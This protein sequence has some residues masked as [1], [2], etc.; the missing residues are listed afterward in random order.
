MCRRNSILFT[1]IAAL[2]WLMAVAAGSPAAADE[3]G[4]YL[5]DR[6]LTRLHAVYLEEKLAEASGEERE[7][8][9]L[10]LASI[11]AILLATTDDPKRRD[12]LEV[13]SRALLEKSP[14]TS[15]DE[16]RLALLRGSYRSAE[17][18]A[19]KYRLRLT[20]EAELDEAKELLRAVIPDLAVLRGQLADQLDLLD[21]RLSRSSG[22]QAADISEE[23]ERVRKL[24]RQCTYLNAWGLYYASFLNERDDN[25]RAAQP[26]F[27]Q[28]MG[29]ESDYPRPDEISRDL[30][31]EESF[32]RS[33]L[34]MAMCQGISASSATAMQWL[35][36]LEH[37]NTIGSL[38]SELPAWRMAIHLGNG[39]FTDAGAVLRAVLEA[40]D[41]NNDISVPSSWLRLAAVYALDAGSGVR[42]AGDLLRFAVAE[43]AT[44]GEL[45]QI[46][47][48]AS[49]YGVQRLGGSGFVLSYVSGVLDYDRAR[50]AHG[51]EEPTTDAALVG[52]YDR[53]IDNFNEAL[54]QPD[55]SQYPSAAA[56]CRQLIAW[57]RY[58]QGRFLDARQAF[59]EAAAHLPPEEAPEALWMAIVSLE[60]A[61][62][63]GMS[64]DV[65]SD[66]AGLIDQFL[67]LYPSH[68]HAPTL[69]Y[70]KALQ[71]VDPSLETVRDLLAIPFDSEVH[72]PAQ[73]R[74]A[75]MLYSLFRSSEGDERVEYGTE[76]L[77]VAVGLLATDDGQFGEGHELE[78]AR[79]LARCRRVLEVS[80]TDGIDR[81]VAAANALRTFDELAASGT[82]DVSEHRDEIDYRRI[83]ERLGWD[84]MEAASGIADAMWGRAPE[85]VW[86]RLAQRAVFRHGRARWKDPETAMLDNRQ[87]LGLVIR[88]GRRVLEEFESDP[89]SLKD[90]RVLMYFAT[91]A[92]AAMTRWE[93]SRGDSDGRLA[94]ELY[95]K[96]V[97]ERPRNGEFLRSIAILTERYGPT[98]Q[99]LEY[100]RRLVA[101]R[102]IGSDQWYEAKFHLI[103]VLFQTDVDRA[104]E[105]MDQHKQLNDEYGPPPWGA[106]LRAL[107]L[108][109]DQKLAAEKSPTQSGG[110]G[111]P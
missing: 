2:A 55:A 18:I 28:L 90:T 64:G 65:R 23:T 88:F 49:R 96:L 104:R 62:E 78:V 42:S 108:R 50:E 85:S 20:D 13:R 43:L 6:G 93:R 32:A 102:T 79:Y 70:R 47:D 25:A 67:D 80:L 7:A 99:A 106:R 92:E 75:Q 35:S 15:A 3:L 54:T 29:A 52:N 40:E 68:E 94:L 36:L 19:E 1:S 97:D 51:G 8:I 60:R 87:A 63:V 98:E 30:R 69:V 74:A 4:S 26:L 73:S 24:Y 16:L 33:I 111:H 86:T 58:F 72:G 83:Q 17:V 38:Q 11:Y 22:T 39:E 44:R 84:D 76:Y 105:V 100:W 34:G 31:S 10:Q 56:A 41:Q 48:L 77:S 45:K 14:R 82:I 12:D 21:R 89:N 46:L 57:C 37:E 107:D 110:G 9:V 103:D 101:G 81:M 61:E 66:L 71:T 59:E 27:A 109:I 91:V 95:Q 53:A 5:E